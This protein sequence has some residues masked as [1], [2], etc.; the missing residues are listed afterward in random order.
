MAKKPYMF[1]I[2]QGGP[3]PPPF[4]HSGSAYEALF[5]FLKEQH[6]SKVSS[7][8]FIG[9]K[10]LTQRTMSRLFKQFKQSNFG[11]F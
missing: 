7:V 9:T 6:M 1:V 11:R 10:S 5:A 4:P 2:F 8:N 3:D